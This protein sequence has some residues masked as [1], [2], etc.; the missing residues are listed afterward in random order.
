MIIE[1][2]AFLRLFLSWRF[3]AHRLPDYGKISQI[4]DIQVPAWTDRPVH[5]RVGLTKFATSRP[6]RVSRAL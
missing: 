6:S 2:P 4:R 1:L 5:A 3:D